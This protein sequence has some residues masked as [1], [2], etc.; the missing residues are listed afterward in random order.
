MKPEPINPMPIDLRAMPLVRDL[1]AVSG[2]KLAQ[3]GIAKLGED[4][5]IGGA[6]ILLG[7]LDDPARISALGQDRKDL[8]IIDNAIARHREDAADDGMRETDI[9]PAAGF[10]RIAAYILA[11][12]VIDAPD[13][14]LRHLHR[15]AA[16]ECKMAGIEEKPDAV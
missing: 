5:W 1:Q 16:R 8:G 15:I 4:R 6:R 9:A 11:M 7:F 10:E 14:F 2:A 13:V 3:I 12:N